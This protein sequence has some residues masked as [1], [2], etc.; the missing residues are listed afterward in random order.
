M[1]T[2]LNQPQ[3][4]VNTV[5]SFVSITAPTFGCIL[6]G[7]LTQYLG[8]YEGP[9]AIPFCLACSIMGCISAI[10]VPFVDDFWL[11]SGCIWNLLFF[12][13]AMVPGL[14]GN[15]I[16]YDLGIMI[17]SIKP[18]LRS[19]ANSNTTMFINLF[20]YLPAPSVYG[21]LS[22]INPRG[23]ITFLMLYPLSTIVFIGVALVINS[24]NNN[25]I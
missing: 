14:T 15:N 12:G 16:E 10:P 7:N 8:G 21:Q 4:L 2:I 6:G 23:G 20:G 24:K 13:G 18:G 19:F 5:F 1:E 3:K 9:Y 25:K 11:I 22:N 17:T